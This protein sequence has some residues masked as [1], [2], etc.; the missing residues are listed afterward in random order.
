MRQLWKNGRDK[1]DGLDFSLKLISYSGPVIPSHYTHMGP[2][3]DRLHKQ[4]SEKNGADD[5]R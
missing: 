3:G 2:S 5:S 4:A 1:E